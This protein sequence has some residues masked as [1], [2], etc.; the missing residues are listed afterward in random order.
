[1]VRLS[2]LRIIDCRLRIDRHSSP[3]EQQRPYQRAAT[4][5]K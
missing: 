1:M 4:R 2:G 3:A 5:Q